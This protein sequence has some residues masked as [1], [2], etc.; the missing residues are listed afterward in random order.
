MEPLQELHGDMY[1]QVRLSHPS[2]ING[3]WT[4]YFDSISVLR[5]DELAG[6][7]VYVVKLQQGEIAPLRLSV[8]AETG[9]VLKIETNLII[10]GLG[11]LPVN[12]VS[13]DYREVHG[14]RIA[15]RSIESNEQTGRT[16]YEVEDFVVNL[17]LADDFFVPR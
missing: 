16:V 12:T 11:G 8:D 7:K 9:D 6:R 15:H 4:A 14:L 10:P 17:D 1:E 5:A 3:D 13:E 2:R